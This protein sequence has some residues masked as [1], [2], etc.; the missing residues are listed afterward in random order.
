M[1]LFPC[2][3]SESETEISA[4]VSGTSPGP[5]LG[6]G[7]RRKLFKQTRLSFAVIEGGSR[8]VKPPANMKRD[9]ETDRGR[10]GRLRK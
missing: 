2:I 4:S 3:G 1:A 8:F 9:I 5:S 6:R 10:Q 7:A